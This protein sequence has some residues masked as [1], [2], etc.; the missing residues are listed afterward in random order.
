MKSANSSLNHHTNICIQHHYAVVSP[1]A[2]LLEA[3]QMMS[4]VG[5]NTSSV[6]PLRSSCVLVLDNQQL[7]GLLTERDLV[8]LAAQQRSL[9]E[10]KVCEVMTRELITCQEWEARE[11]MRLIQ[12]LRQHRIRHLP[13]LNEQ[14]QPVGLVTQSSICSVLEPVDLLKFRY[15]R[16]VMAENVIHAP[17][18]ATVLELVQLMDSHHVS[19]IV[20]GDEVKPGKILP[21]GI[22]TERDI[23]QFQTLEMNLSELPAQQVMSYP[24]FLVN[25][26]DSLWET[27]QVIQQQNI[28][29]FVVANNQ[30]YLA[31]ILTQTNIL[32]AVDI[33]GLH[34]IIATLQQQVEKLE[35]EKL[36][37]LKHLNRDL[38][39]QVSDRNT[40]LQTQDQR[41]QL[42]T[43]V[44]FRIR[45]SLSLETILQTTVTE[46]RQLLEVER[47]IIYRFYPDWGGQVT[48]ESVETPQW[49]ILGRIIKDECF[50]QNWLD[51]YHNKSSQAI[52]DIHQVG[53][54]AC[55]IEFLTQFQIKANLVVPISVDDSLWGLLIAHSCTDVRQ[56][57]PDEVEFL[58]HLSIQVA[59]A[60]Q[61]ATLLEQVQRANT[62][63][64]AK[65]A[66]RTTELQVANQRLQQELVRAQQ[67]EAALREREA[68]VRSFYDSAPMMMGVVE[69]LDDDMLHLSDNSTTARFFGTTPEAM[70]NQLAS[71]MGAPIEHIR[72]WIRHYGE[73]QRTG[74]P[75]RFEYQHIID[76]KVKWL[77]ATVCYIGLADSDRPRFSYVVDDVSER[78]AVEAE[79]VYLS[80]LLEA[81]LN[82]IYVF[83]AETFRFKYVN[84][85][86]LQNLGYSLE[87][88]QD[89]T[90]LDIKPELTADQF[91]S[92][93]A[94]LL[95]GQE[96]IIQFQSIHQR[97]DNSRYPSE[98]HLQLM[99]QSE[100][101]VFL[102]VILDITQRQQA[103]KQV[104]F[105]A[106]LLAQVSDAVV[107][108]DITHR[109]I[110]WN[111]A[112]EKQ[113][114]IKAQQALG[115][116]LSECYQY[117]WLKPKDEAKSNEALATAGF[118]Q[119]EN[120]HRQLNGKEIFVES[121]VSILEDEQGNNMGMLALIRDISERVRLEAERKQVEAALQKSE[122][123]YRRIVETTTEG[124]WMLDVEGKTSFVNAKMSAM[125]GYSVEE[126][127][128]K[129]LF[130]FM[131]IAEQKIAQTYLERRNQGI[132]EQHDFKFRRQD[133][134]DLWTIVSTTPIVDATGRYLGALAM[135]TDIT[136]RKQIESALKD[137]EERWQL[138]LRGSN[139]GIWDWNLQTNEVFLSDR[140]KEMRGFQPHE[141]SNSIEQWT[142][143]I[144][145]EDIEKVRNKLDDHLSRKTPFFSSEYRVQRQDGSYIWILNRG[146][147]LWD[148][149]G[150]ILRMVGLESDISY[151]KQAEAALRESEQR[152]RVLVTHAPVGIFQADEQGN[153]L[154]INPRWS[155]LTGISLP[156]ALGKGWVQAVH[157][158]DRENIFTEWNNF[159]QAG[160]YFS[161]EYRFCKP[162]GE[163]IW[164]S[165]QAVAIYNEADEIISYFVT[166]MDITA[167]KHA[168][169]ELRLKNLALEEAKRQAETANQ[170]KS[171][172]LANMS[173]EIRTPM[174]AILG[175]ADLLQ[176]EATAPHIASYVQA[177]A[178][179]GRTLLALI[180]DI[181][182]LSK[183]ESGKLELHY[184]PVDLQGLI[185]EILQI[186]S[187]YASDK[188]LIL[189]STIEDTVPQSIYIDE[190]RL[191]Q[192][193][194]NVVGN[195]LKFTDKGYIQISIRA[196]LYF[197]N[198]E[199]KVWL[200]IAVE[201]TGI[202]IAREQQQSIFEAF[203]QSSGQSNRKYGGTGL[204]LAI[205]KRLMNMM[206]GIITLQ[207]ELER[208]SIFTFVFPAV[209]P[210]NG[211]KEIVPESAQDDDLN[212]FAPSTILVVD[213]VASNRELIKAYFHKTHH[214]VMLVEDGQQAINL[215]QLHYP[216]LILLDLRMPRM[217]G[218]ETAQHL[219]EDEKTKNI[220]IVILTASSQAQEQYELEQICQGFLS[221]PISCI[222][223]VQELR[224]H[225]QTV[226]TVENSNQLDSCNTNIELQQFLNIPINLPDLLIK[227]EEEE[228]KVWTSLRKTFK[229]RELK[230]FI[231]RL[232]A[233]GKEYQ[234]QFLVD[235]ADSLQTKLDA[236]DMEQLPL[237]IEQFPSVRQAIE[238]LI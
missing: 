23:V 193:L 49:S 171:E 177:I 130:A 94:P 116:P 21:M 125:L 169:K 15:V 211:L 54:S 208:G 173:H 59:N 62:E 185:R 207:S 40:K 148:E 201:D 105:Q 88:M 123:Q 52:A 200:E 91:Q 80:N 226:I 230:Q 132:E 165:G 190:V 9:R 8:K 97:V 5:D 71:Q 60:I 13:V 32:Q 109:V 154:Y 157:P 128:G 120:I 64:E 25:P 56:W 48:V 34:Q 2:S 75:V 101:R 127:L 161:M 222:E 136:G 187:P 178:S 16:E 215:A 103:E 30:G 145:P 65:V 146:Q 72:T 31:G 114:G 144:H 100:K 11:P 186:F 156:E 77:S 22:V 182:D 112:A 36:N 162:D 236:F 176:S 194:F 113:Y 4:Q 10:T 205:T 81:S 179:S 209:S 57:Q 43:A 160:H 212:Q 61:Q 235:Y 225:L 142:S 192:I 115:K 172:F 55:H 83:D 121:S 12:L 37:L 50:E 221:K 188:N 213:D 51:S 47:V 29:R 210:A 135:L 159:T 69:L 129:P 131:G 174:N 152:Y 217:D 107:A 26:D 237:I 7:V 38:T 86:A 133:G 28:R 122:E 202:G 218:K 46:V 183:I 164:V 139:D 67:A 227:L 14:D 90:P 219:K 231:L 41:N 158:D 44:A 138:A 229:M 189:H 167:R 24:L 149:T 18:T 102:A 104:K 96:K 198:T 168:E 155:E 118:W 191:R 6:N 68:A 147:A 82:E 224:K 150:K 134:S 197:I 84:Q 137:S 110:H 1:N 78:K 106:Q 87:Q 206:D 74:Q 199:E 233:W 153:C 3:V 141:L 63:L 175:F 19:C 45:A 17:P 223:L 124:I 184:E 119:G 98:V 42:L 181:L 33:K 89:M 70:H 204:G 238:A 220:P 170:A 99:E 232:K 234:C 79:K 108:V 20:I 126:M 76:G 143:R 58:E 53:L 73:S 111:T 140:W 39:E 92:L 216:D 180:N 117:R 93:I 85:G 35:N 95:S 196:H 195:A 66:E 151:R 27:Y 163:V 166:V 203:V 214:L 228:E